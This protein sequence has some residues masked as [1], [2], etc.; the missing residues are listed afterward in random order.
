MKK[1][2][3]MGKTRESNQETHQKVENSTTGRIREPSCLNSCSIC[4][5]LSFLPYEKASF[6]NLFLRETISTKKRRAKTQQ[7]A[8]FWREVKI[9]TAL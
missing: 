6:L 2:E 8:V 5:S 7:V 3:N 9:L 4:H 1:F